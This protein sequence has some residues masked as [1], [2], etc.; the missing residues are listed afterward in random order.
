[1]DKEPQEGR[2]RHVDQ[3]QISSHHPLDDRAPWSIRAELE[4]VPEPLSKVLSVDLG[5]KWKRLKRIHNA[6]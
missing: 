5:L 6:L 4:T 3:R 1:M 2:M